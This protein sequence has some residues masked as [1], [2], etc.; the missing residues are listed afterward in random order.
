MALAPAREFD[1]RPAALAAGLLLSLPFL[2]PWH[3]LPVPSFYSEWLAF[4]LGLVAL[5]AVCLCRVP[6]RIPAIALA[7][8]ALATVVLLQL[9]LGQVGHPANALL[10]LGF[11]LWSALLAIA[12]A[13]A[14]A[15]RATL[16]W[17]LLAGSLANAC[18]GLI[19]YAGLAAALSAVLFPA[20]SM[21]LYGIVGNLA[22]ANHFA[23]HLA[24]GLAALAWLR[25][26]GRLG[27][28]PAAALALLLLT[29]LALSGSR[30]I[31][32]YLGWL[33]ALWLLARGRPVRLVWLAVL[34]LGALAALWLAARYAL[35]GP[36]LA[37]LLLFDE[38]AGPRAY[39]WGHALEMARA[40]PLL[41]VG[42]DR[43]AE[44]LVGQLRDAEKVWDIDQYAH[45]L[46]LQL[47]AVTG[48]AGLTAVA[49]PAVLF[50]RRL[51]RDGIN[52]ASLWPW[53][54][55][56]V[57]FIHSM[58]EQ[59]LYYAYFLGVAA[60]VAGAADGQVWSIAWQRPARAALLALAGAGL[61]TLALT[62]VDFRA[63]HASF[64]A[65]DGAA[66]DTGDAPQRALL[67]ALQRRSVFAPYA[68]LLAPELFSSPSAPAQLAFN[69]RLLR[70]APTAEV[71]FRHALLLA[72][73]GQPVAACVQ[74]TRAARAYPDKAAEYT[75]R[76]VG[77]AAMG[78]EV[79]RLAVFALNLQRGVPLAV[80]GI[81]R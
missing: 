61:V 47:L 75:E 28:R 24:L 59:P 38:G 8:A 62:A 11:L 67:L 73:A 56:G 15:S 48:L 45:N 13:S 26:N 22:Q 35:L 6:L 58:L 60:W 80:D 49:L 43:F 12:A 72:V 39:L 51:A 65:Q 33:G 36:Q 3:Q 20:P 18:F 55:L 19:Q 32:L 46:G 16:A 5:V 63:L 9:A 42:I 31:L 53:G 74:W 7:P 1:S 40:H 41:G 50:A 25:A 69:A 21:A 70:F 30:T 81:S 78:V 29:A 37:R 68:E 66:Q 54:V 77:S 23:A 71:E 10:A 52:A 79:G 76:L 2:L 34:M 27:S 44:A 14:R 17:C 64:Y 57:L 4:A